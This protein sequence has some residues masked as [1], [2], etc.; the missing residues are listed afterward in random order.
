MIVVFFEMA[1]VGKVR[2][3]KPSNRNRGQHF[4]GLKTLKLL[5]LISHFL[6]ILLF[7]LVSPFKKPKTYFG[8][9]FY[10]LLLFQCRIP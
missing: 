10:F 7:K 9:H 3:T 1:G 6:Q 8:F 2:E 5:K 4:A